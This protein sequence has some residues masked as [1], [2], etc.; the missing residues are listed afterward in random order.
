MAAAWLYALY[1][2]LGIG[3]GFFAGLLGVGGGIVVTPV[4]IDI[5]NQHLEFDR[6]ITTHLAIG[7]TFGIILLTAPFSVWTHA[8]LGNVVWRLGIPMGGI[9]IIGSYIGSLIAAFATQWLLQIFLIG[10]LFFNAYR[11]F[12]PQKIKN[13]TAAESINATAPQTID[14]NRG[15]SKTA[16]LPP[17]AKLLPAAFVIGIFSAVAGIAGGMLTVPL[18]TH[19]KIPI[20]AAIGTAAFVGLFIAIAAAAGYVINGIVVNTEPLPEGAWGFIYLPALLPIAL[21]S[22]IAA[23]AGAR[24]TARLPARKLR[25]IFGTLTALLGLRLTWILL[26]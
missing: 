12:M 21:F 15:E 4:L 22:G 1:A 18:L 2:L 5:F 13:E 3:A 11:M 14:N 6:A 24:L 17:L 19:F 25:I 9:I 20:H 26:A 7:T 23:V 10:I 8:R 16:A